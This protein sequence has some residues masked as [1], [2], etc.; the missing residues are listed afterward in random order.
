MTKKERHTVKVAMPDGTWLNAVH[1]K[2]GVISPPP[3][4]TSTTPP[5]KGRKNKPG[6]VRPS[7][8][9]ARGH[10][11]QAHMKYKSRQRKQRNQPKS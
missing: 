3:T 11:K 9:G 2:P 8:A 5:L 10:K 6:G 7:H 1:P 4:T